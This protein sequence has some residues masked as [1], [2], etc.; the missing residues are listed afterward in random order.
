[1]FVV[2][3]DRPWAGTPFLVQGFLANDSEDIE[4]LRSLCLEVVID[5]RRSAA[6]SLTELLDLYQLP[7]EAAKPNDSENMVRVRYVQNALA[8]PRPGFNPAWVDL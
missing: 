1:M 5:P 2:D 4:T 8:R 6:D 3:L 7:E